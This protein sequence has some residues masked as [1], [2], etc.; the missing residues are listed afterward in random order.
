MYVWVTLVLD[1]GE[2]D[3]TSDAIETA[4]NAMTAMDYIV[5]IEDVMEFDVID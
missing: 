3:S 5:L 2:Q 1:V 4:K